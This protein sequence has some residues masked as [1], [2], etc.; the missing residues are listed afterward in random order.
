M[1]IQMIVYMFIFAY[2]VLSIF[3]T[4]AYLWIKPKIILWKGVMSNVYG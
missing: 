2:G 1:P 4:L 3:G